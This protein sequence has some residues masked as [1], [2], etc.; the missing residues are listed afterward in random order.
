[1]RHKCGMRDVLRHEARI[2]AVGLATVAIYWG[3][4]LWL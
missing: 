2:W 4:K 3:V 1:M